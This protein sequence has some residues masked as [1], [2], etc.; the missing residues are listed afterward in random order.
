MK[1]PSWSG[2]AVDGSAAAPDAAFVDLVR[3]ALLHPYDA[4][5]LQTHPL[6]SLAETEDSSSATTPRRGKLL[7]QALMSAIESLRPPPSES[8]DPRASRSY[9]LLELRY[10]E[11]MASA[12]VQNELAISKTQYG[13][14]HGR[15]LLA[16]ASLLWDRWRPTA[17]S[18][19]PAAAS[20]REALAMTETDQIVSQLRS[21]PVALAGVLGGLAAVS[22]LVQQQGRATFDF[23]VPSD[24]PLVVADGGGLQ[25]SLRVLL[26]AA[27]E[28]SSTVSVEA[29]AGRDV[30]S[31]EI[32]AHAC[33]PSPAAAGPAELVVARRLVEAM[34]GELTIADDPDGWRALVALRPA[35]RPI[36]LVLDNNADFVA[37]VRRYLAQE[38][39]R[40]VGAASVAEAVSLAREAP[41]DAV[42]LDVMLPG[43]DGWDLL[44]AL[45]ERP[46]TA[47]LPVFV[48]S[49]LYEPQVASALG[50]AGYLPKPVTAEQLVEALAPWRYRCRQPVA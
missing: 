4:T 12:D 26:N 48:C 32:A 25:Q 17:A 21:G 1:R 42:L 6:A 28:R 30:V 45:R 27:L 35:D 37:L 14:D 19:A 47:S 29:R 20:S 15:A 18:S 34:G 9:R 16:V 2:D 39:W 49:V 31:I 41:P 5:Y 38:D 40:V 11:A 44:L 50:A 24:L 43:E 13:R 3:D 10:L 7:L 36:L 23:H 22:R 46:E 33:R 8:T